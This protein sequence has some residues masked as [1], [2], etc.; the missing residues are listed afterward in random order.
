[1]KAAAKVAGTG[2]S[3]DP[4]EAV[5]S[6]KL[7]QP[8]GKA[9]L[10]TTAKGKDGGGL[11]LK[12]GLQLAKFAGSMYLNVMTGRAMMSAMGAMTAKN[13]GG[14]G[15]LNN[16]ALMSMQSRGLGLGAGLG[17]GFGGG[18][19][20]TA[21]AASFLMKQAMD[22]SPAGLPG[23]QGPSFDAALGN[24]LEAASNTVAESLKKG[25]A[26]AR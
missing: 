5:L 26:S 9:R 3:K 15:M 16:P 17:A 1:M 7:L 13:L 25:G 2:P 4:T 14:M 11:D 8:D 10:S 22:V 12:T 24:A 21:G 19:D 20:P 23:Q 18:L 6:Y